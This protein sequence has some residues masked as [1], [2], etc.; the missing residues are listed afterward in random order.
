[1]KIG[2]VA[3]CLNTAHVRGVGRFL[4]E[5][6]IQSHQVPGLDWWLLGGNTQEP[7]L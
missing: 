1:M 5:L 6:L 2:L 7:L 4:R 3:R